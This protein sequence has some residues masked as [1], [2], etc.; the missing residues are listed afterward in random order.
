VGASLLKKKEQHM[1]TT[2]EEIHA[3][4]DRLSPEK[5]RRVLEFVHELEKDTDELEA[6]RALPKSSLPPGTPGWKLLYFSI[7]SE[8][9]AAMEKAIEDCERID[10]DG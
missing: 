1:A 9:T 2:I 8:D 6:L 7:P 5:Q 4:V 3:V 10:T